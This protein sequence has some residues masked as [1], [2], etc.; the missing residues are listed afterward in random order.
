MV[1]LTKSF[2][3]IQLWMDYR[4]KGTWIGRRNRDGPPRITKGEKGTITSFP[5]CR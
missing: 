2:Y 3:F 1:I 4:K 5:N